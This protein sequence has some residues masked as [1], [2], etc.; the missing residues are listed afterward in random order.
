MPLPV[1]V[2]V[3]VPP[4]VPL[5]ATPA[6]VKPVTGVLKTMVKLMGDV[7]VGS[8]WLTAWLMVTVGRFST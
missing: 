3:F 6:L 4:A 5:V 8:A 1:R 2:F 7:F